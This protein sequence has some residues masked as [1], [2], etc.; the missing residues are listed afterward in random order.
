VTIDNQ[1]WVFARA[2][3]VALDRRDVPSAEAVLAAYLGYMDSKWLRSCGS[4]R[5]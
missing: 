1:E 4:C 3:D 2:Y 5:A